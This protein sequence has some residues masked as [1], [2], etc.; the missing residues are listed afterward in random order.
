MYTINHSRVVAVSLIA[1]IG[2]WIAYFFQAFPRDK[3]IAPLDI[4]ESLEKPWAECGDVSVLNASSYDA[5]SQY[6]P[7]DYSIYDS[8]KRDGYVGWNPN[9]HGGTSIRENHMLCPFSL[10]HT[11]YRLLPFWDAWDWGRMF[12]YL[13]AA[14]GMVFLLA[15]AGIYGIPALLGAMAFTFS[16]QMVV[17]IHSDV[18]ASGCCWSPWMIWSLY[19]LKR[20][21]EST[22]IGKMKPRTGKCCHVAPYIMLASAFTGAALQ[23]GF[24]HT[25]LFNLTVLLLWLTAEYSRNASSQSRSLRLVLA[26]ISIGLVIT[27]PW[28][29]EV[30]PPAILGGHALHGHSFLSGLKRLPTVVTCLVPTILGSPQGIDGM[31]FFGSD[32]LEIKFAGGTAL[33]LASLSLFQRDAPRFPKLLFVLF[34]AIPFTPLSKWYYHRCFVISA[35]GIGWLASWRLQW[36]FKNPPSAAYR[37]VLRLFFAAS[38]LWMIASLALQILEPALLPAFQ[39]YVVSSLPP[40]KASRAGWMV[41]R[42]A[43]FFSDAKIWTPRALLTVLFLAL[44]LYASSKVSS[45][46]RKNRTFCAIAVLSTFAELYLFGATVFYAAPRPVGSGNSPYPDREWTV[47][48]KSHLGNGSVVFWQPPRNEG[49]DF[50]YMQLNAPSACGIRQAE[51]YESVQPRRIAPID[52]KAF[53]PSDFARAGISHVSTPHGKTFPN[54]SVWKLVESS[55]EFDLY[56]NPAFQSI[57]MA[58]LA[59]GETAALEAQDSTSNSFTLSLP[60]GTTGLTVSISF[61]KKWKF[62]LGDSSEW[63]PFVPD[64]NWGMHVDFPEPSRTRVEMTCRFDP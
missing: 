57:F 23:C 38:C 5:I 60:T 64:G 33:V 62:R 1:I 47:R 37:P 49:F 11:F 9:V 52:R 3:V 28:F 8:L 13:I 25:A 53:D 56:A 14:I 51:G 22:A 16:S 35:L 43:R 12:H 18:I 21:S 39:N 36:Q 10:R 34:L 63:K 59:G 54:S 30:V 58:T 31:K 15:E 46:N 41:V 48:F 44:G 4:L 55:P 32:F 24:L 50:D 61:H 42:A 26:A 45:S 2:L 40:E 29:A 17:W 19:R 20:I 6:I 27:L 7:Y